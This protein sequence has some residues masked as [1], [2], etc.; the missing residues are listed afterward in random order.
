MTT[1][2]TVKKARKNYKEYGIKKGETYYWWAFRFRGKQMSKT[3]PRPSQLT[4]SGFLSEWLSIEERIEDLTEVTQDDIYEI[5][6]QL[7]EL[8]DETQE[9]FDNMPESLQ[10]GSTGEL[11]QQRIDRCDEVISELEDI[12]IDE[13]AEDYDDQDVLESVQGIDLTIE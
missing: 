3:Y 13:D 7:E 9:K 1:V 11:L 5:K 10:E 12:E 8:R 6:S 2:H 4:Q